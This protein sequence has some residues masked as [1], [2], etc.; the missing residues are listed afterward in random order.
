MSTYISFL[1]E[2]RWIGLISFGILLENLFEVLTRTKFYLK[3][4]S[5]RF[6]LKKDFQGQ[7]L[8]FLQ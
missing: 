1:P 6:I 4:V 7:D 8:T 2:L 3:V 5:G